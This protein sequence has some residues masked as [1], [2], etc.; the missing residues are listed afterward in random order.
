MKQTLPKTI[1][2]LF[3]CLL[4]GIVI[5]SV[6]FC[7]RP[8]NSEASFRQMLDTARHYLN[9]NDTVKYV[10]VNTCKQCHQDIYNTFIHTGMGESFGIATRQKSSARFGPHIA[11]YDSLRDLY[12]HPF[13]KMDSLYVMEYRISGSRAAHHLT[14]EAKNNT[15]AGDTIYKRIQ[16]INYIIGSGQ[17]TNSHLYSINGFLFQAPITYYTQQGVWDLAP[18]FS[19]G[20]NSRFM[21][22]IGLE[23]MTCHNSY[24]GFVEGSANKYVSVPG[25]IACERCHGAGGMHV[26]AIQL[27]HIVDT[28]KAVDYTIVNPAKLPLDLQI[29]L[30]Q[31]CHLQGNAVL[32][33]GKSFY[34]FKP[35]MRLSDVMDVFLPKYEGMEDEHIMASHAARLEMSRC[36]LQSRGKGEKST[37]LKP[38]TDGLTCVTCHNPHIDVR[39]VT[40]NAFN[41]VCI[42]CHKESAPGFC[43]KILEQQSE[44]KAGKAVDKNCVKCHMPKGN[45]LDIPHVV[46]TDHFIRIPEA[47]DKKKQNRIRR[48]FALYDANNPHP[49]SE[50]RGRAFIQQFERFQSDYPAYLDSAKSCFPDATPMQVRRNFQWLVYICFLK[51]NFNGIISYLNILG[52]KTV[53]DS[54]LIHPGYDN[55]DAI[56]A[57]QVGEAFSSAGVNS[58]AL[59]FYEKAVTLAPY[60]LEY[61][62][63]LGSAEALLG[64]YTDA[65]ETYDY[66]LNQ[67]PQFVSA[68]TNKGYLALVQGNLTSANGYNSA[69]LALDPDNTQ[70]LMNM[71]QYYILKRNYKEAQD[72]LRRVLIRYP[73]DAVVKEAMAKLEAMAKHGEQ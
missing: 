46:T 11:V 38:Y 24:P 54:L 1:R 13:W 72:Y 3:G 57:Y 45:D 9:L 66:I 62:N 44:A 41:A 30:C 43:R 6:S 39:S 52:L 37:S 40:D 19:G 61:R 26:R 25:G 34:S 56:A 42:N 47:P 33:S 70:A 51:N 60:Q 8:V 18:G 73:Q 49:D 59:L 2:N 64:R 10:G 7:H 36:F 35:G 55:S 65:A 20:F 12:Y 32:K 4:G 17:H 48:F 69:A 23:C 31:R 27:G 53:L 29:D 28:A 63:K 22:E 50:T 15:T 16:Q 5:Y 58:S 71:A 21:R 14:E 68:L 67:D